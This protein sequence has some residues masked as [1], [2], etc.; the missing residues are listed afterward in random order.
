[1]AMSRPCDACREPVKGAASSMQLPPFSNTATSKTAPA[2][3]QMLQQRQLSCN[4]DVLRGYPVHT[5][6]HP[7]NTALLLWQQTAMQ[8]QPGQSLMHCANSRRLPWAFSDRMENWVMPMQQ[9]QQTRTSDC[10]LRRM[11]WATINLQ[12]LMLQH[13]C[14]PL[15][16]LLMQSGQRMC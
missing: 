13:Q 15:H 10:P 6:S 12:G 3:T 5:H 14:L 9:V 1:M 7:M 4:K 2:W 8:Q 11:M 16:R